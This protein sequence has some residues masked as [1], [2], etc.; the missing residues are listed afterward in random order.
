[1]DDINDDLVNITPQQYQL[2]QTENKKDQLINKMWTYIRY[3]EELIEVQK[4][5]GM[6]WSTPTQFIEM[7]N[8]IV[9]LRSEL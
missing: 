1:M 4:Q 5:M 7:H 2:K 9:K 8:E 6:W 3:V